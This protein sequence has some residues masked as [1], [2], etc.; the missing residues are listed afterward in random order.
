MAM[1]YTVSDV[2]GA[3]GITV[4]TLH[5]Y[6][7]IGV[8]RPS[9][10]SPSG[11][12]IYDE[13]DL[14]RLQEVLFFRELGFGLGEIRTSLGDPSLDRRQVLLRQRSLMADQV[15]RFRQMVKAI[16]RAL[17][18]IDEGV[19]MDKEEMFEIFGDFDPTE[20]ED[21]ARERWGDTDMYEESQR[22]TGS[23]S[24]DEWMKLGAE[25]RAIGEGLAVL[26]AAGVEATSEA[27]MD[28]AEQHRQHI[29]RWFY[30][31]SYEIHVGLGEMYVADPRFTK[32]W[33]AFHPGLAPYT[34]DAFVANASRAT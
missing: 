11:Y 14:E 1:T 16:D 23:Y 3:T 7:E 17:D 5:H 29:S 33:D 19:V 20:Y 8:L 32:Y 6:D 2:A 27:A 34:R 18:A 10:R 30:Q 4:R 31:C 28:F 12:R 22:R 21:E 13:A 26:M 25:G 24:K 9:E 15:K